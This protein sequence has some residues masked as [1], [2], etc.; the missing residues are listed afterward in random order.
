M[1]SLTKKLIAVL[2]VLLVGFLAIWV[3]RIVEMTSH[4]GSLQQVGER[5]LYELTRQTE[6][7]TRH[8]FWLIAIGFVCLFGLIGH[9]GRCLGKTR[10]HDN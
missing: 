8:I 7:N 2:A 4:S 10:P 3:P 6:E 5:N 9:Y 1:S